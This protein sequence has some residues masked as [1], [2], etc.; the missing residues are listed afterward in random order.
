M[1]IEE[2]FVHV[3]TKINQG[4]CI[5]GLMKLLLNMVVISN[6]HICVYI[7]KRNEKVIIYLLMHVNDIF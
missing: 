7:L 1:F 3:E 5:V 6:Y 4:K 2:I